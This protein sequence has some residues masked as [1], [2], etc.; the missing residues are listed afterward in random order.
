MIGEEEKGQTENE[1]GVIEVTGLS[2]KTTYTN[3][4]IKVYDNAGLTEVTIPIAV[5]TKHEICK[6][7]YCEGGSKVTCTACGGNGKQ[8]GGYHSYSFTKTFNSSQSDSKQYCWHCNYRHEEHT[9][10]YNQFTCSACAQVVNLM[11]C[12]R[13]SEYALS[14]Y[15]RQ[16]R[17]SGLWRPSVRVLHAV[18]RDK[19]MPHAHMVRLLHTIHVN[20]TKFVILQNMK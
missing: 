12:K 20:I 7:T 9:W 1:D 4:Y 16:G 3:V 6:T 11:A 10:H 13:I 8:G 2:P 17:N 14:N 5:T 15:A 19:K 18:E